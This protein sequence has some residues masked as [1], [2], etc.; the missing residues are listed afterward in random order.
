MT[1]E[2]EEYVP[3]KGEGDVQYVKRTRCRRDC[4][5][6][7]EPADYKRGLSLINARNNPA[8]SGYGKDDISWCTDGE[9]YL[10]EAH[11]MEFLAPTGYTNAGLWTLSTYPH[12]GLYWC[13]EIVKAESTLSIKI[14][15]QS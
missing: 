10:C 8:S 9:K 5:V 13:D 15:V 14:E 4:D 6:C 12:L 11:K 3:L 7:G 2:T 1:T